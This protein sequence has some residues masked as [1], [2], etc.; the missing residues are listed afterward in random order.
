MLRLKLLHKT[1]VLWSL[2][3]S[4]ACASSD[5]ESLV[6]ECFS[7][8][9]ILIEITI[10][11]KNSHLELVAFSFKGKSLSQPELLTDFT[12]DQY[13]RALVDE[14]SVTFNLGERSI[15]LSEYHSEEFG[16][17]ETIISVT[18]KHLKQTQYFECEAGSSSNLSLLFKE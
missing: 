12:L 9:P 16:E 13:H 7:S 18:L 8:Q 1:V 5:M 15:L 4:S 6:F 11:Q 14:K 17:A 2:I 10:H 3:S